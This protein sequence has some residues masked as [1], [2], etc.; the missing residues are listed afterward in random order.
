MT[1]QSRHILIVLL[2]AS[3]ILTGAL[4]L[5]RT[6]GMDEEGG[7]AQKPEDVPR[8]ASVLSQLD[9]K[10]PIIWH[11]RYSKAGRFTFWASGACSIQRTSAW[12]SDVGLERVIRDTSLFHP[13]GIARADIPSDVYTHFEK[14]DSVWFGKPDKIGNVELNVAHHDGRFT[15]VIFD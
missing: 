13:S 12:G 5:F 6:Y 8:F 4:L 7:V 14:G 9:A 11:Y 2:I 10:A 1:R 3:L 15:L